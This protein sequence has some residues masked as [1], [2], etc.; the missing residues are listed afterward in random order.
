MLLN[1]AKYSQYSLDRLAFFWYIHTLKSALLP[2]AVIPAPAY[3]RVNSGGNP[4]LCAATPFSTRT[5]KV[6]VST[7]VDVRT[8]TWKGTAMTTKSITLATDGQKDAALRLVEEVGKDALRELGFS[9]D[10]A[11]RLLKRG[12]EFKGRLYKLLTPLVQEFSAAP[13]IVVVPDL[14]AIDLTA[15]AKR[16]L[17][18][19]YID[20]DYAQWDYY[21]G[22]D[23]SVIKGRGL[24]FE[25]LVVPKTDIKPSD[26]NASSE[27]IHA[28]FHGRGFAGH[29]GAF[30][31][32]RR[33]NPGLSGYHATVLEENACWRY[34]GGDL[35]VPSSSF[36]RDY[37]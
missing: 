32:W 2:I 3:A 37:R 22:V 4:S 36:G 15:L 21:T 24:T 35:C 10:D 20:P 13:S 11:Q 16:D 7:C 9:K 25:A 14:S 27:E 26:K 12:G 6:G 23:G 18:L 30:T 34:D 17:D 1:K 31:Q 19:T 8:A 33:Q 5:A 29:A 28:Y